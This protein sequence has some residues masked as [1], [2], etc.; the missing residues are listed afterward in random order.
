MFFK[1]IARKQHAEHGNFVRASNDLSVAP[2][3]RDGRALR[4]GILEGW[5]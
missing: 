1:T 3:G 5:V 2:G 4:Q